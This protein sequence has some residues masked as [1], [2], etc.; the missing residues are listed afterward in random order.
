MIADLVVCV[1]LPVELGMFASGALYGLYQKDLPW[2]WYVR[3]LGWGLF[4]ALWPFTLPWLLWESW[5]EH[6]RRSRH[7]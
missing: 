6:R 7:D 5:R 2:P 4:F 3:V 1:L